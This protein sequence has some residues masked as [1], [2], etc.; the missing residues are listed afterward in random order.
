MEKYSRVGLA[1]DDDMA[2]AHFTLGT[3]GNR[4]TLMEY[5]SILAFVLNNGYTKAPQ[6]H[7][8][9]TLAVVF[10]MYY[11][12]D[13]AMSTFK[14]HKDIN[15]KVHNKISIGLRCILITTLKDDNHIVLINI[16]SEIYV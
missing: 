1:T 11:F 6:C 4:H 7:V 2:H 5:V 14:V 10:F 9:P 8:I 16:S 15:E 3:K 13:D 12:K